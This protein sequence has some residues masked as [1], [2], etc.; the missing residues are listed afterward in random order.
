MSKELPN[1]QN[2]DEIDLIIFFNLIGNAFS[3]LFSGLK[4]ILNYFF[5]KIV[6][7]FKVV[8][9]NWK[10]VLGS[11]LLAM[12]IGYALEKIKNDSYSTSMLVE[13]Y[14]NS[15]YQL[16]NNVGYFNALIAN[17][18]KEALKRIFNIDDETVK[19]IKKFDIEPG[20][21]TENDRILQYESFISK[22]DTI[23][24]QEY[25]YETFIDNRS[26]YSGKYF[27]ISAYA[28]KADI[29]KSLEQGIL[30]SFSNN[31]SG[32]EMERRDVLIELQK[33]NLREQLKEVDSLKNIYIDVLKDK[34]IN[35]NKAV[36]L[37]DVLVSGTSDQK[38]TREYDLF[39]EDQ[40]IRNA[41]KQLDEKKIREDRVYDVMIP[42]QKVGTK[43]T[44]WKSRYSIL[45]PVLT[46]VLLLLFFVFKSAINYILNYEE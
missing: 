44:S 15:K 21:E 40:R 17:N 34:T 23:R 22:L 41:L 42:F 46:F 38:L 32:K 3:K 26:V 1:N 31:Y 19:N 7:A 9:V 30:S 45:F 4:N 28:S 2:N 12:V 43:V 29:F 20:P 27:L 35:N 6:Y 37:G 13:P 18:D 36:N 10:T 14:F 25:S 16:V 33:K 39:R 8:L 11:M 24:A 5:S